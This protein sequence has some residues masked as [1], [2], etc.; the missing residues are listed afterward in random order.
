M[1]AIVDI[2]GKQY[3]VE[4][5][6]YVVVDS[7]PADVDQELTLDQFRL[8]LAGEDS[9]IGAPYVEGAQVKAVVKRHARGPKILVYKMRCKKGYRRKNGHRQGFTELVIQQFE[10]PGREKFP[11]ATVTQSEPP[12]TE[13]SVE[14]NTAPKKVAAPKKKPSPEVASTEVPEQAE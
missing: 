10:F 3:E 9:L 12:T 6:R 1:K 2:Q 14:K 5:G 11:V 8:I 7:F 4:E 13:A